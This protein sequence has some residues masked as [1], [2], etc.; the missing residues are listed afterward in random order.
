MS[1]QILQ[2]FNERIDRANL[3]DNVRIVY[4]VRGGMPH[5]AVDQELRVSGSGIANFMKR[6]VLGKTSLQELSTQLNQAESQEIF[7]LVKSGLDSLPTRSEARFLPDSLVGSI[8][9]EIDGEEETFYFLADEDDRVVQNKPIPLE[10]IKAIELLT[11][12]SQRTQN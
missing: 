8:T 3:N 6:S 7:R 12:I 1:R 2:R 11:E 4:R 10:L 9:V 5:E